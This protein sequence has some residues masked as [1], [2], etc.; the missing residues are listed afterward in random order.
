M[1]I[2]LHLVFSNAFFPF[3]TL[4]WVLIF[5]CLLFFYLGTFLPVFVGIGERVKKIGADKVGADGISSFIHLFYFIYLFSSVYAGWE[6]FSRLQEMGVDI[7]NFSAVRQNIIFDFSGD[8]SLY[9]LFKIFYAGVGFCIFFIAF[10]RQITSKQLGLI[11][12]IGLVSAL[13]T[14]GRLYLL[15]YFMSSA[16]LL[17][18][19]KFISVRGVLISGLIFV[20]LFF[21]VAILMGKG[22][23]AG[24]ASL[25]ENIL[26]NSQVYLMS[27]ISC[28]NDYLVTGSQSVEGGLLMPNPLREMLSAAGWNIPLKPVL[29]Q[30]S[31]VPVQCNTYTFLF[32]LYHDG[33]FFGVAL[34]SLLVGALHQYLYLL[35]IYTRAPTWG[36]LYAISIYALFMTIFEDAYFSSPGFWILLLIP[37]ASF[38]MFNRI[39]YAFKRLSV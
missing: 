12:T 6:I 33:A 32:P 3:D 35:F 39:K 11:L 20:G 38:Y 25:L 28:F 34:G 30:F 8:R 7:L 9:G 19:E 24:T 21:L 29:N 23:D 16:A 22:D 1:Q 14:T 26:W 18:R 37:P 27:S 2:G 36:Y 13:I 17:Y 5:S 31:E 10:A 15:L 4:T